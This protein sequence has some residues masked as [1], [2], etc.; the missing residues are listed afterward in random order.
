[1]ERGV[2]RIGGLTSKL[3]QY[4]G[5]FCG[6]EEGLSK[7]EKRLPYRVGDGR[8]GGGGEGGAGVPRCSKN[9]QKGISNKQ[10]R[11]GLQ[12]G[13]KTKDWGRSNQTISPDKMLK[14]GGGGGRP[15]DTRR[16]VR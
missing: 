2:E 13:A 7:K 3:E 6:G 16:G 12:G 5:V 9:V 1:L 14:R 11:R 15:K 4:G 8:R 10:A